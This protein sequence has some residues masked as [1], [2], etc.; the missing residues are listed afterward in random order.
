MYLRLEQAA[1][2]IRSFELQFVP[3]LLQTEEYARSVVLLGHRGSPP[4]DVDQRVQLRMGRQ[5]MLLEPGAPQLWVVIDEA[6]VSRPYGTPAVMR[7][8]LEHL[9]EASRWPNVTVQLLPFRAGSHAAAGGPFSIL[10]F[11]ESDLPDIVY[12]E[13]LNSAV[14]LDKRSD[15]EDYSGVWERLVVQALTPRD[16]RTALAGLIEKF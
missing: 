10:R 9:L 1:K 15:V 4:E 14:Y 16:T 13:Q 11:A 5:K 7:G 8:Q 6:A 3:G 2:V 12:L